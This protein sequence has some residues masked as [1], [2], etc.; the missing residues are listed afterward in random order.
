MSEQI[1]DIPYLTGSHRFLQ[2][3]TIDTNF[4]DYD[5]GFY[6]D[7]GSPIYPRYLESNQFLGISL[8]NTIEPI[9][10]FELFKQPLKGEV[11]VNGAEISVRNHKYC[12]SKISNS[13]TSQTWYFKAIKD[14]TYTIAAFS[15]DSAYG[16]GYLKVKDSIGRTYLKDVSAGSTTGGGGYFPNL[17]PI[18]SEVTGRVFIEIYTID[19]QPEDPPFTQEVDIRVTN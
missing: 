10:L 6:D 3:I 19:S 18:Q 13:G 16:T 7:H 12:K 4:E 5:L 15:G 11:L 14:S 2:G 8:K 1:V 9:K 17:Y